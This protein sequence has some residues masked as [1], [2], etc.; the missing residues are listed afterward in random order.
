MQVRHS[1]HGAD[2]FGNSVAIAQTAMTDGTVDV[3][4]LLSALEHLGG[5]RQRN[6]LN[7][8]RRAGYPAGVYR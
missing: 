3:K 7:K 4:E 2:A 8:V 6:V 1:R 5:D